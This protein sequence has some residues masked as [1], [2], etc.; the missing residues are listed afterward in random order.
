MTFR[1]FALVPAAIAAWLACATA[2]ADEPDGTVT[3]RQEYVGVELAALSVGTDAAGPGFGG[4]LRIGRRRWSHG[5]WTP[6]QFGIFA[7][8][9]D[10]DETI[11]VKAQTEAGALFHSPAGALELGLGIGG[12]FVGMKTSES[13]CDGACG[14][15]GAGVLL[16]PVLRY[17]FHDGGTHTVGIFIRAEVPLEAKEGE[18]LFYIR[19]FGWTSLIGFDLGG[20]LN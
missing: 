1:F 17:V 10:F 20:G 3:L 8:G 19:D 7:G 9:D 18:A 15:G 5:Y 12:G 4:T 6:L 11:V 13:G 14:T 16:S 2:R